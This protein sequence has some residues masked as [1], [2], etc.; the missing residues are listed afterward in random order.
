MVCL[1]RCLVVLSP[2]LFFL[3]GRLSREFLGGRAM[4]G[5]SSR[6]PDAVGRCPPYPRQPLPDSVSE[7]RFL[8]SPHLTVFLLSHEHMSE[9]LRGERVVTT[10]PQHSPLAPWLCSGNPEDFDG[11]ILM[12]WVFF[13]HMSLRDEHGGF[14]YLPRFYVRVAS[15]GIAPFTM[16][17]TSEWHEQANQTMAL[18][19]CGRSVHHVPL[20]WVLPIL[21]LRGQR[22]APVLPEW[23]CEILSHEV[24]I[25]RH[26][27]RSSKHLLGTTC[28]DDR[29][30][31]PR[32]QPDFGAPSS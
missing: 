4:A 8:A 10:P 2:L 23:E 19:A 21:L 32:S 26:C 13:R 14:T 17:M 27:L 5:D 15:E 11:P 18:P 7:T 1:Y 20:R 30:K 25:H 9:V 6:D 22:E 16:Q 29:D 12:S 3:A 24:I 28:Y 31:A